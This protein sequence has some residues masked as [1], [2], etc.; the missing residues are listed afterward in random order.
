MGRAGYMAL[1]IELELIPVGHPVYMALLG[2]IRNSSDPDHEMDI[3]ILDIVKVHRRKE[4][5]T[6]DPFQSFVHLTLFHGS[7]PP[8]H[9]GIIYEGLLQAPSTGNF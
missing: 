8:N 6:K 3:T 4:R 2:Y 9:K 1:D 5:A 7:G